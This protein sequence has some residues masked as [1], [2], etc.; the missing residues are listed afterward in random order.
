MASARARPF[1]LVKIGLISFALLKIGPLHLRTLNITFVLKIVVISKMSDSTLNPVRTITYLNLNEFPN[2]SAWKARPK[3]TF[4]TGV[5]LKRD[6]NLTLNDLIF[7]QQTIITPADGSKQT[8]LVESLSMNKN[9]FMRFIFHDA[10]EIAH[11]LE[12]E[13]TVNGRIQLTAGL[14]VEVSIVTKL[15]E[16]Y[17]FEIIYHRIIIF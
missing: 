12:Y 10:K 9:T 4:M 14:S 7:S 5:I 17:K 15:N 8:L 2:V 16:V 11:A 6:K 1:L 3:G 13:R